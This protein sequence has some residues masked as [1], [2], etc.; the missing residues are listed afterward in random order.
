MFYQFKFMNFS[1]AE[2]FFKCKPSQ[3]TGGSLRAGLFS[4]CLTCTYSL[5]HVHQNV[6]LLC[7]RTN[8][9]FF[10]G[11]CLLIR[12]SQSFCCNCTTCLKLPCSA[13]LF[14]D[15]CSHLCSCISQSVAPHI[16]PL[17]KSLLWMCDYFWI[18]CVQGRVAPVFAV[19]SSRVLESCEHE[20]VSV[21]YLQFQLCPSSAVRLLCFPLS[22]ADPP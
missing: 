18:S 15:F 13:F 17:I 1:A 5:L 9:A 19:I 14:D 20:C 21:L 4:G 22:I 6:F 3:L 10:C 8:A 11:F 16:L 7:F 12:H 2:D